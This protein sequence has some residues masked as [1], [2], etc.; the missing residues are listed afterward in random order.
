MKK[1]VIVSTVPRSFLT[2]LKG[3][4]KYLSNFYEVELVSSFDKY[5]KDIEDFEGVRLHVINM[6]RRITP[7][8]DL[9]SLILLFFYFKSCKPEIVY[10]I[11]PK[12]G[13]LSMIAAFFAGVPLRVHSVIGMP[14]MEAKGVKL[15]VLKIVEKITYSF[16][17]KLLCNSFGL[18]DYIGQNIT[19]KE[20]RVI[21][22]G[23]V[24]GIDTHYFKDTFTQSQKEYIKK[25]LNITPNDCV[26]IYIGRV[27]KDKG[28]DE[29]VEAFTSLQELN[30]EL[31]LLIIGEMEEHLNPVDHGTL[32]IIASHENIIYK[33]FSM[34]IRKYLSISDIF[35]LPSYREGL[36][37]ILLEAGSFG[38]P[39]ITTNINGCNEIVVNYKNGLL[40]EKKDAD[41][42]KSAVNSLITDRKLYRFLKSNARS[43][44]K[45]KFSQDYFHKE[46][47]KEFK[48]P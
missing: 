21:G 3:Q 33:D 26:L 48:A 44:I 25:Q 4:A 15:F 6:S 38:V 7:F 46:L 10:S 32:Q 29:L 27:V 40:I 20:I 22:Y 47:L 45:S 8:S 14:L 42:I 17:N 39:I 13:L 11:S 1:M 31:K 30:K 41:S 35:L 9:K 16:S 34:D 5:N 23:S 12:A 2:F 28:I 36:P 43:C 37:N 18:R 24:N 19:N